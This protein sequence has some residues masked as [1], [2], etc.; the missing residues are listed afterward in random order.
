MSNNTLLVGVLVLFV[1]LCVSAALNCYL[2][3]SVIRKMDSENDRIR[4]QRNELLVKHEGWFYPS[5]KLGRRWA[6][7]P[8]DKI[9]TWEQWR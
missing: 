9:D 1:A 8:R 5:T 3:M 6:C 4:V 7:P 2:T